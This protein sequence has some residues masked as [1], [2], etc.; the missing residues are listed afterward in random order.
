MVRSAN[1]Y[2]LSCH[3]GAMIG[4]TG[5]VS[6]KTENSFISA[7]ISGHYYVAFCGRSRHGDPSSY[8]LRPP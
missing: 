6:T 4:V 8:L 5:S 2:G 3:E 7:V 1:P